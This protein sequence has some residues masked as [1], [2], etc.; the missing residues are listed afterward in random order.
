MMSAEENFL[1][2]RQ[3]V[4]A[5][6]LSAGFGKAFAQTGGVALHQPHSGS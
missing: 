4:V 3:L 2:R 5:A 1:S 6:L